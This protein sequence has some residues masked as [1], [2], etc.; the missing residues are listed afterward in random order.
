MRSHYSVRSLLLIFAI[1][2]TTFP[3]LLF[4]TFQVVEEFREGN[5]EAAE[6]NHR[7]ARLIQEQIQGNIQRYKALLEGMSLQVDI[8]TLHPREP[9]RIKKLLAEYPA[10]LGIVIANEKAVSVE[11]YSLRSEIPTGIDYSDRLQMIQARNTKT[12]AVSGNAQGRA[13][14]VAGIG[15]VIPLM[16]E[17]EEV[18]GFFGG[19]IPPENLGIDSHLSPDEY[20]VVMDSF[21]R[22]VILDSGKTGVATTDLERL[23]KELAGSTDGTQKFHVG[24]ADVDIQVLSIQPIG[25]KV[26]VGVDPRV[27]AARSNEAVKRTVVFAVVCALAGVGIMSIV[28]IA[29]ARGVAGVR[30]QLEKM[31][32][33]DLRPIHISEKQFVPEEW[34]N[35]IAK[36]NQLLERTAKTKLA[37]LEAISRVVDSIMITTSD[38]TI[39]YTNEAGVRTFG[40]VNGRNL[41]ELIKQSIP[42]NEWKGDITAVRTDGTTFD[43][44]LSSTPILDDGQITSIVVI[45]QDITKEKA[46]RESEAQSEKMITLGELVAGTSH[47]LNNPLAIVTGYSDLLLE[48]G[49]L[50]PEQQIRIEAIR[51]SALRA[52][53][54][55]H[56]LLAFAR[57]RKPERIRTDV[58]SAVEATAQLKQNDLKTSG[59]TLKMELKPSIPPVFVD[60]NQLRQVL[61]NIINNSQDALLQQTG[62]RMI[63][64]R[65]ADRGQMVLITIIDNGPGISK[66]DLK[67]VFDPFFTTKPVG[68]GT[69][70]GLSISYGIIREH[71]GDIAIQSEAGEGTQVFIELPVDQSVSKPADTSAISAKSLRSLRI[72]VIDDEPEIVQILRAGLTR[73]GL[74]VDSACSIADA[75]S[76]VTKISYDFV[77]TD[78]KMPGGSG[79]ELYKML[80]KVNPDYR[81]RTL[82]LTGDMS[83]PATVQFLEQEGL[84]YFSKPFDFQA[85]DHY[86]RKMVHP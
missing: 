37:E 1:V 13:L 58:N 28:S 32:A 38:G 69:G 86:F 43:G 14:Q 64:M 17:H 21:N 51:K 50:S 8:R 73:P 79:V 22:T 49:G 6:I 2:F 42:A 68:K 78:V 82:F 12:T 46:A 71:N 35:L 54:V 72:L 77:V 65:T 26:F 36:F 3:I 25:W 20:V 15:F 23:A 34:R 47:E 27:L 80:C 76:L 56:S 59:I 7:S 41:K 85:L 9:E 30:G 84:P 81:N 55:V 62:E 4:G 61:L 39:T 66:A 11:T 31:S 24:S 29:T 70:L 44:F 19:L 52:S 5:K 63:T 75:L 74:T 57:K 33:V 48:D 45:I 60:P 67:K 83:N 16:D 53:S 10:V 18:R 40:S